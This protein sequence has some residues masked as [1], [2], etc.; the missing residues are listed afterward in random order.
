[1][2]HQARVISAMLA[3]VLAVFAVTRRS[4]AF[5][6]IFAG[7]SNGVDVVTHQNGYVGVGGD[8]TLTIGIDPTSAHA[9]EMVTSTRNTIYVWNALSPTT[10]NLLLGGAND[11]PSGYVDFESTLLHEMGH[12]L[13]LGHPNLGARTGITGTDTNFTASTDGANNVFDL[14]AGPDGVIGSS[15]DIRGD[16]VNLNWFRKSDNDPLAIAATV[17]STTYGRDL[18]D[19]PDGHNYSA[20]ADRGVGTLLGYSNTEAV[21]QQGAY[22]DEAQRTLGHDDAAGIKYSLTGLDETAG[23]NDDYTLTLQYAG[24]TSSADI[25]IDF[26]NNKANFAATYLNGAWIGGTDHMRI[27]SSPIYFNTGYDWHFNDE[28]VPEPA[29]MGL[30]ALGGLALLKRRRKS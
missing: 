20:N 3:A 10:G 7:E 17:D 29:T 25:V 11:I 2:R 19:L 24:K 15:D 23:T 5:S 9:D 21:L 12:A 28:L 4:D 6:F 27:T 22:Y 14:A 30:L 16:D 1:M 18:S 26:D 8:L 13:G